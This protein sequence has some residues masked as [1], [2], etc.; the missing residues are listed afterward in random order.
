MQLP[1]WPT[2]YKQWTHSFSGLW[3][4]LLIDR[5]QNNLHPTLSLPHQLSIFSALPFFSSFF[6]SPFFPSHCQSH[7]F[8]RS[9]KW[10]CFSAQ[11]RQWWCSNIVI[12]YLLKGAE[13]TVLTFS[14]LLFFFLLLLTLC[15][16]SYVSQRAD[17]LIKVQLTLP[18]WRQIRTCLSIAHIKA[19][20]AQFYITGEQFATVFLTLSHS[21][22]F[23]LLQWP[24]VFVEQSIICQSIKHQTWSP[25]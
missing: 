20:S 12:Q 24:A 14:L 10:N 21:V 6:S 8:D 9:L 25:L 23:L 15:S 5:V 17:R 11:V 2:L 1:I 19:A 22:F 18:H 4:P 13:L 7:L 16:L 3:V